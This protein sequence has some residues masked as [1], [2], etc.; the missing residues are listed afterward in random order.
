MS[1]LLSCA[2][3]FQQLSQLRLQCFEFVLSSTPPLGLGL[4]LATHLGFNQF[5][6]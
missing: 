6:D 3:D 5:L 4:G 2:L 1:Q